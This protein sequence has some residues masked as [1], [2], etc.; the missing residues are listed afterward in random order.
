MGEAKRRREQEARMRAQ[1]GAGPSPEAAGRDCPAGC[2]IDAASEFLDA[3]IAELD[4]HVSQFAGESAIEARFKQYA[5]GQTQVQLWV[6][7]PLG[8][9]QLPQAQLWDVLNVRTDD[10]A[11]RDQWLAELLDE[12][13]VDK[14]S[15]TS[16]FVH[17]QDDRE[18][19]ALFDLHPQRF[20]TLHPLGKRA[21]HLKCGSFTSTAMDAL[22]NA[23]ISMGAEMMKTQRLR[24]SLTRS[25]R[26]QQ[27]AMEAAMFFHA[28]CTGGR[29]IFKFP[30][31]IIEMFRRT[32]VDGIPLEEL[33]LPFD[34]FYMHFGRQDEFAVDGWAPDG[35][36]VAQIGEGDHRVIQFAMTF[37]PDQSIVYDHYMEF[38]EPVYVQAIGNEKLKIGVGEAIDL[39]YS[40]KVAELKQQMEAGVGEEKLAEAQRRAPPGVQVIDATKKNAEI[41]LSY[42]GGQHAE[43]QQLLRLV[44]NGLAY[45]SAYPE[46]RERRFQ[47]GAPEDLVQTAR[48]GVG[49]DARRAESK[50]QQLGY[51]AIHFCG[52][53]TEP[54]TASTGSGPNE[55]AEEAVEHTDFTWVRGHWRRQAHGPGR[56]LRTLRWLMPFKRG[57]NRPAS[58][59]HGHVYLVS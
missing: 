58:D 25:S 24:V 53:K 12:G 7:R 34:T 16:T 10:A 13:M 42:I 35:A 11:G 14:V 44:V 22:G 38:P 59:E 18:H 50:L 33:R 3:S 29:Q 1:E 47:E 37:S 48:S 4:E 40:E 9:R 46:D 17:L 49:N 41:E 2:S 43:W 31:R 27:K 57:I 55:E 52:T 54:S 20:G 56:A 8:P 23:Q 19:S 45:L 39:V 28:F 5:P 36:Y 6:H 51:T 21:A 32:D 30:A 26:L 15:P